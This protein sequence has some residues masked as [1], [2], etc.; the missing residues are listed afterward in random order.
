ML[1]LEKIQE[2]PAPTNDQI[3]H[4]KHLCGI[5]SIYLPD[6]TVGL[7]IGLDAHYLFRQLDARFGSAGSPDVIKTP[8]GWVLFGPSLV[9]SRAKQ[10]QDSSACM[11][12]VVSENEENLAPHKYAVPCGLPNSSSR[13]NRTGLEFM[14]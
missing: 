9:R 3:G 4:L 6:K 14:K 10:D 13:E 11:N 5:S 8:L 1:T 2:T 7:L 12:V